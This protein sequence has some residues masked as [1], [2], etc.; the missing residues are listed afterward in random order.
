[1]HPWARHIIH[2][3]FLVKEA[4]SHWIL[5]SGKTR[6]NFCFFEE[7]SLK[8][9]INIK[10]DTI[11]TYLYQLETSGRLLELSSA[12]EFERMVLKSPDSSMTWVA[13]MTFYLN[14]AEVDKARGVLERGLQT[15]NYR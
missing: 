4:N 13:Y 8:I 11:V 3:S 1:M 14:M 7:V 12:E 5:L 10:V 2:I 15:I 6:M 9:Q